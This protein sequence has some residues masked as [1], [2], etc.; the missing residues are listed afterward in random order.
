MNKLYS[1]VFFCIAT[2]STSFGQYAADFKVYK[3]DPT[4]TR[5][6]EKL[7]QSLVGDGVVLKSYAITKTS[8][9]EAFGFFED[10]K[11]R[12]GIKHGLIMTTGGIVGLSSKNTSPAMSNNTHRAAETRQY[13]PKKE[14]G[15]PDLERLLGEG[16]KTYDACVIEV[17]IVPT[18][19]TLS[20]NYVFGSEEYD[21]YV[22]TEFNDAFAFLIDGPGISKET[23]L[24]VLPGTDI[25]V[26]INT[27]NG[28]G[29]SG[30]RAS[31]STYFVSNVNG[32]A[33][34]EYD[35]LTKLMQI[36]QPVKS[37]ETY[38]IKLAIADVS[39]E[40]FDS[41]VFIEGR[42][43]V[44]YDK[45]YNVLYENNNHEIS[46]GYKH[47][48][49]ALAK[50]YKEKTGANIIITGHTDADGETEANKELSCKRA[51]GVAN[52]L[53][54]KGVQENRIS[55]NCKGESMPVDN[56]I[57]DKGKAN[58]RRTEIKLAG[59]T[60]AYADKKK[61]EVGT[62]SAGVALSNYPNPFSESTTIE[63]VI[64]ENIKDA[65][66][67]VTDI[68]GK[69]IKVIYLLE[70][71]KTSAIFDSRGLAEGVYNATLLTD[72]QPAGTIKMVV[73]K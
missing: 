62:A 21:E 34:I 31:N 50:E 19:D 4:G 46:A 45:T 11:E 40:S 73:Q 5:T 42:S 72:G 65:Y 32:N 18:A 26:S 17:D 61:Q 2:V 67:A 20:F 60:I 7:L 28:G 27:V 35:G 66:I 55:L 69:N 36:R 12:L 33:G 3:C 52:Y 47:M 59:G 51:T 41:G 37:Y 1:L 43:I 68:T 9:D 6:A 30:L 70:R 44:S 71:G 10:K 22:G 56:N 57:T 63:A 8:S 38:H 48:L 24:A 14:C 53:I 58:N 15:S 54:E 29:P 49:D 13:E 16:H 25:P 23:N 39:D 64:A